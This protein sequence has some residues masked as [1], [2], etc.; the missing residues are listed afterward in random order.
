MTDAL[1]N[2]SFRLLSA[3]VLFSLMSTILLVGLAWGGLSNSQAVHGQEIRVLKEKQ[4]SIRDTV[5]KIQISVGKIE[6]NQ[7]S[8]KDSAG[9]AAQERLR[10]EEKLDKITDRLLER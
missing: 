7:E 6:S 10:I 1:S 9:K 8:Q 3:E 4:E 2:K 5:T